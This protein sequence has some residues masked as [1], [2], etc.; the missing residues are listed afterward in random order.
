LSTAGRKDDHIRINLEEDVGFR[1]LTTGLEYYQFIHQALPEIDLDAVDASVVLF[2]KSLCA[3]IL[4]SS[5][6]GGTAQAGL[7]NRRLAEAVQA[8]RLGL[9]VGSH[10]SAEQHLCPVSGCQGRAQYPAVSLEA[11]PDAGS[12]RHSGR[13]ALAGL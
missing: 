2:G 8:K 3:P 9:G 13:P 1:Q 6:T 10:R 5:M 12:L 4:V 11:G 7:F